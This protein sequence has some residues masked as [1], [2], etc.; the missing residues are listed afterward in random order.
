[1]LSLTN[2][3]IAWLVWLGLGLVYLLTR[4]RMREQIWQLVQLF[5]ARPILLSV[6]AMLVYVGVWVLLLSA[7]HL[8]QWDNLKTTLLWCMTF[9]FVT[10]TDVNRIAEDDTFY[11]K[12][13]RDT[14]SA[15]ALVVF[16]T[17]L[18][19]FS[20][21]AEL[22][23]VPGLVVL[24][25]CVAIV[26][27]RAEAKDARWLVEGIAS[28]TV[29]VL[30]G[31][32]VSE[33]WREPSWVALREF[34]IPVILSL[35]F[36]PF[37]YA[38][39]IY[40]TYERIFTRLAF[41]IRDESLRRYAQAK[42]IFAFAGDLD[43]LRRWGRNLGIDRSES[44]EDLDRSIREVLEAK[45]REQSPPHVPAELGWSPYSAQAFLES[46]GLKTDDYHKSY[47]D[48]WWASSLREIDDAILPSTIDY[49][50]E[51]SKLAAT[52]LK[53]RLK[54]FITTQENA[55]QKDAARREFARMAVILARAAVPD[56]APERVSETVMA[57]TG[58]VD[59]GQA[60]GIRVSQENWKNA[61]L[62][63]YELVLSVV[64]PRHEN[65]HSEFAFEE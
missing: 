18:K 7:L 59:A 38:A 57:G 14:F 29:L 24:G 63:G 19:S 41:V 31:Y 64:H 53:L 39:S 46:E 9:A 44:R 60:L 54:V 58:W 62:S 43:G 30:L 6:G 51:G 2:R 21:P 49:V 5:C 33:I 28:V 40:V 12:S 25:V 4:K 55:A 32:G 27:T 34:I 13:V 35:L 10:M 8:W 45:Q 23:I 17:E 22:F 48:L 61:N 65:A 3:E 42:S 20:L 52:R 50:I 15:T 37:I 16:L 56:I 1:M 47:D 26:Q 11:S 36:L